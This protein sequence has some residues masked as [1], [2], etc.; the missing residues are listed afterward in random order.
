M[1]AL[2]DPMAPML[3]RACLAG[4]VA[5]IEEELQNGRT[6]PHMRDRNGE[7]CL[8][9]AAR[10]GNSKGFERMLEKVSSLDQTNHNGQTALHVAVNLEKLNIVRIIVQH[11]GDLDCTTKFSCM[12]PLHLACRYGLEQI[13][14]C[15][16]DSGANCAIR[17]KIQKWPD[18][19][20]SSPT[21]L[22]TFD[23][24]FEV[25]THG[26]RKLH[27]AQS[28]DNNISLLYTCSLLDSALSSL[29]YNP[30]QKL[31]A[32]R[33][34]NYGVVRDAA[35]VAVLDDDSEVEKIR[36]Q[37]RQNRE[38]GGPEHG[39]IQHGDVEIFEE[40]A[41]YDPEK[42]ADEAGKIK[43]NDKKWK[44]NHKM[45][46]SDQ[47]K[48]RMQQNVFDRLLGATKKK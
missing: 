27:S 26:R 5:L 14:Q 2:V 6:D 47:H 15:L 34:D 37:D 32:P 30:A 29:D 17:D 35:G 38:R 39:D 20:T 10:G 22:H 18:F 7:T 40:R 41:T 46:F 43:R 9:M 3:W 48:M 31:T 19:Y 21:I 11:G 1:P 44:I 24:H 33:V 4:D 28:H 36:A 45:D 16:L 13:V 8:H 25:C 42:I 23:K 12:T